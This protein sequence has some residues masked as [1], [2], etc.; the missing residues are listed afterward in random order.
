[1]EWH[2]LFKLVVQSKITTLP[3]AGPQLIGVLLTPNFIKIELLQSHS[4]VEV[5]GMAVQYIKTLIQ[6]ILFLSIVMEFVLVLVEASASSG[7]DGSSVTGLILGF[8]KVALEI[9]LT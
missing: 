6:L 1:M 5:P 8:I 9:V 3:V 7:A 2:W 4:I